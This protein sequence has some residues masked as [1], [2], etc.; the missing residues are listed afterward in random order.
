ML[1]MLDASQLLLESGDAAAARNWL[2]EAVAKMENAQGSEFMQYMAIPTEI[3]LGLKA[4]ALVSAKLMGTKGYVAVAIT[5]IEVR[6]LACTHDAL[7]K[8]QVSPARKG[9]DEHT[10]AFEKKLESLNV[11]AALIDSDALDE[12]EQLLNATESSL[13]DLSKISIVPELQSERAV[14]LAKRGEYA[15][16]LAQALMI[17]RDEV[18]NSERG[19]ALRIVASLKTKAKGASATHEW[20]TSLS[21]AED[22]AYVLIG[23]LE[24]V[25]GIDD[26]RL[27]YNALQI[28]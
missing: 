23:I 15:Q 2:E 4:R 12:A 10:S 26:V 17:R 14:L 5:C 9:E 21:S 18:S 13:D 20:A 8:M 16:A 25:L 11:A 1:A 6:D 22:R 19:D 27:P 28:H 7:A 3:K 24:A